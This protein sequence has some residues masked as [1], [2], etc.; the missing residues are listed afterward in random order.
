MKWIFWKQRAISK[1]N[2]Y[3]DQSTAFFFKSVKQ[4]ASKMEIRALQNAQDEWATDKKAMSNQFFSHFVAMYEGPQRSMEETHHRDGLIKEWLQDIPKLTSDQIL[5]LERP[6]LEKEIKAAVFAPH[7]LKSPGP[8]GAPPLFF[9]ENWMAIKKEII[10][11]VQHFF[12]TC[13][14]LKEENKTFINLIPKLKQPAKVD[15][16][17]LISL[18]NSFYKIIS[19]CFV[20]RLKG[21]LASIIGGFQ[22]AFVPDRLMIDNCFVAHEILNHVKHRKKGG[23]F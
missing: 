11:G 9:Q 20:N 23:I 22:N 3:G 4:R 2:L 5:W 6:F 1:W 7:P 19:K 21:N 8:N 13:N 14:M 18:C 15:E 12:R 16:F 10:K 17:R